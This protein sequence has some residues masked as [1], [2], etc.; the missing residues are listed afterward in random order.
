MDSMANDLQAS[1]CTGTSTSTA[2]VLFAPDKTGKTDKTDTQDGQDGRTKEMEST[3]CTPDNGEPDGLSSESSS[4]ATPSSP[5]LPPVKP[6][7]Y[8]R[9]TR[10]PPGEI[11]HR[12]AMG[13]CTY[14]D[15]DTHSRTTCA[16]GRLMRRVPKRVLNTR[17]G[18]SVCP[19]C[20]DPDHDKH[21]KATCPLRIKLQEVLDAK[22]AAFR[23]NDVA[24]ARSQPTAADAIIAALER[25]SERE[26]ASCA[27]PPPRYNNRRT[28]ASA[29]RT[30]R[31]DWRGFSYNVREQERKH[32]YGQ[33]KYQDKGQDQDRD[34][35]HN[36]PPRK[37]AYI[38]RPPMSK[39]NAPWRAG[40]VHSVPVPEADP[41]VHIHTAAKHDQD[42]VDL[43]DLEMDTSPP[44]DGSTDSSTDSDEN[45]S[46][47]S[48]PL[49]T[50]EKEA[51]N[52]PSG[53]NFKRLQ[54][55]K[56]KL[57]PPP[58]FNLLDTEVTEVVW[59]NIVIPPFNVAIPETAP[60]EDYG[61][62]EDLID[63][64][65]DLDLDME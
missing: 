3:P 20:G 32:G 14:C 54:G 58:Q 10:L 47:S 18:R 13:R 6:R 51:V 40:L 46:A 65:I 56:G 33:D 9:V 16:S 62:G 37:K 43:I 21:C 60:E 8:Y 59:K 44:S 63:W 49:T 64:G 27:F 5:S 52:V 15:D 25:Q 23:S 42:Q 29:S 24:A 1:A 45:N 57:A 53:T 7:A 34:F 12:A 41:V 50:P 48:T 26:L 31:S 28:S 39:T 38:R 17:L 36:Q 55:D 4:T 2:L 61:G 19:F 35:T 22:E 11:E 30:Q